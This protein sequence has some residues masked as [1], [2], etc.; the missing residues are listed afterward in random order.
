LLLKLESRGVVGGR[1][2]SGVRSGRGVLSGVHR[3]RTLLSE[4]LLLL[5]LLS[6][7]GGGSRSILP[8]REALVVRELLLLLLLLVRVRS[9]TAVG[10]GSR[11]LSGRT[12]THGVL[13]G[14][15]VGKEDGSVRR[16]R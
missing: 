4:L 3:G 7:E 8:G 10:L 15:S 2:S 12:G 1:G 5:L 13:L 16:T 6:V 9:G 11:V 14:E